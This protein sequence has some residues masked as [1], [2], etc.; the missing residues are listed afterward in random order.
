MQ[1]LLAALLTL[2][3]SI[4]LTPGV[5]RAAVDL[6]LNLRPGASYRVRSEN[7]NRMVQSMAGIEMEM[8]QK[9]VIYYTFTV[10]KTE[11][12]ERYILS[13]RHEAV[14]LELDGLK[15]ELRWDSNV[16]SKPEH[17]LARGLAALVG[18]SYTVSLDSRGKVLDVDGLERLA[19]KM[20]R[21]VDLPEGDNREMVV[22]GL[23]EMAGEEVQR[24][25][26]GQMFGVYPTGPVDIGQSWSVVD[27][28]GTVPLR[29]RASL[30]LRELDNKE[31]VIGLVAVM[32]TGDGGMRRDLGPLQ[33]EM[34]LA[35]TQT[36][37][38]RLDLKS[39]WITHREL[40]I[41]VSGNYS[42]IDGP[43]FFSGKEMPV[44]MESRIT[45]E[46]Y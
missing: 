4:G 26:L 16:D 5:S 20:S 34:D 15:G 6:R 43:E 14:S 45:W 13:V 39:G 40:N 2:I 46:P 19:E 3:F 9:I 30:T 21:Q 25:M 17:P 8:S 22:G 42:L 31:A 18:E 41:D 32:N 35:G 28:G 1:A 24:Q 29:R 12:K 11:P 44:R 33:V 36:G 7:Y 38:F 23:R 10:E 27:S 37:T